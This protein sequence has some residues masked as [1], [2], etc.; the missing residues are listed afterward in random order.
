[1]KLL[2]YHQE[3]D[4]DGP[5][6]LWQEDRYAQQGNLE[7]RDAHG[8]ASHS[9]DCERPQ[10][11]SCPSLAANSSATWRDRYSQI[12]QTGMNGGNFDLLRFEV[13]S[14]EME[15]IAK[16]DKYISYKTNP[17]PLETVVGGPDWLC[18][19]STDIFD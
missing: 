3:I 16:L 17:N 12:H 9:K 8:V 2:E 18:P 4:D 13:S 15:N 7:L 5:S 1:M 11:D 19:K 14:E 10:V 6:I